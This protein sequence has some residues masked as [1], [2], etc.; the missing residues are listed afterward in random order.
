MSTDKDKNVSPSD[1]LRKSVDLWLQWDQCESTRKEIE[2]L[3]VFIF[4]LDKLKI[5]K[6]FV[7]ERMNQNGMN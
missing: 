6:N 7:I 1:E 3:K 5:K 4:F 2:Q